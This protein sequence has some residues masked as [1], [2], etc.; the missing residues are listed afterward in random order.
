MV[1]VDSV[2]L[3]QEPWI[4]GRIPI[5]G[6]MLNV[7]YNFN[8]QKLTYKSVGKFL[9]DHLGPGEELSQKRVGLLEDTRVGQENGPAS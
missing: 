9:S 5:I 7:L 3:W 2:P 1:S 4:A 8:L 6:P